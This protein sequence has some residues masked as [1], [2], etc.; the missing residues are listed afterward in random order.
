MPARRT[1]NVRRVAPRRKLVWSRM[2]RT[3]TITTASGGEIVNLMQNLET[4]LGSVLIGA[5]VMRIRGVILFNWGAT[6]GLQS[7]NAV[8]VGFR[9]VSS[10]R[11]SATF[12]NLSTAAAIGAQSPLGTTGRHQDWFGYYTAAAPANNWLEREIDVK[13]HRKI[14]EVDQG[15]A[16]VVGSS[17][18]IP[19]SSIEVTSQLSV[20]VALH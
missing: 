20:L 6:T 10:A 1:R 11:D 16:M 14:D 13:S 19:A 17:Q 18:L 2:L 8:G 12:G 3:T 5:T 15:I 4:D 7:L 9:Q